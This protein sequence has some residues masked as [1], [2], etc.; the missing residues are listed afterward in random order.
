MRLVP[1]MIDANLTK[2][3]LVILG[4]LESHFDHP[5]LVLGRSLFTNW[6]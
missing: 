6:S 3:T 5:V 4:T 1:E 2:L